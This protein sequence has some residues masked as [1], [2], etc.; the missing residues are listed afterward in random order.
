MLQVLLLDYT[1]NYSIIINFKLTLRKKFIRN[2]ISRKMINER[3]RAK[4]ASLLKESAERADHV[5][6]ESAERA[7][8][9]VEESAERADLV[10]K[11]S[12]VRADPVVENAIADTNDVADEHGMTSISS[13]VQT[14]NEAGFVSAMKIALQVQFDLSN[15]ENTFH[16]RMR[17]CSRMDLAHYKSEWPS[18]FT[19]EGVFF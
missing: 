6:E 1:N 12:A 14:D 17:D 15:H 10:V 8:H 2:C 11:E 4:K 19:F 13:L 7:D 9:V 5:V 16:L 18:S 3:A